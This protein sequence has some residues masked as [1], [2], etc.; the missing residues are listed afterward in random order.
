MPVS[1][2]I[3]AQLQELNAKYMANQISPE[4]Y[5]KRRAEILAKP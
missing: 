2:D 3:E 1:A 5:H 4:E